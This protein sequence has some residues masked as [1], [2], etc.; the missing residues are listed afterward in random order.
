MKRFKYAFQGMMILFK[1]DSK[2]F[3]HVLVG[4]VTIICGWF[5]QISTLDWLMIVIAIGLVLAFEAINTAVEYVV[6]LVTTEYDP[7]AKHAKDVAAF[8]VM[9]ASIVALVIGLVVF[10]P[11]LF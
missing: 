2:F 6:D 5:F 1:K 9:L 4:I 10:L 7:L 8:S 3:M 11:Y